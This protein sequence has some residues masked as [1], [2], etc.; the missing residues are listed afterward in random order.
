[1]RKELVLV[2]DNIASYNEYVSDRVLNA[3]DV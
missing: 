2:K 1:M 3:E